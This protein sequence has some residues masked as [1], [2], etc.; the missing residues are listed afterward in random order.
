[1]REA[2]E[3]R[4]AADAVDPDVDV[5]VAEQRRELRDH[6]A[7]VVAAISAGGVIGSLSRYGLGEAF[8]H[9]PGSWPWATWGI[10]VSGCL[11]IGVLMVFVGEAWTR[12]R[13]IRPFLGVGVLGGFT[14]FSTATVDVQQ[15]V[16]RGAAGLG[17]VYLVGTVMSALV[18]VAAGSGVTRW[19]LGAARARRS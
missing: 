15:L 19:A 7:S 1:M 13:L 3:P 5:H 9:Q 17:L 12:Q 4:F 2:R 10:N 14:T 8:P 11:L 6:P 18:A 16:G